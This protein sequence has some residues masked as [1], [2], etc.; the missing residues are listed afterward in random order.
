MVNIWKNIAII[1]SIVFLQV[2]SRY[3]SLSAHCFYPLCHKQTMHKYACLVQLSGKPY[4]NVRAPSNPQGSLSQTCVPHPTLREGVHKCACPVQSAGKPFTNVRGSSNPL[5]KPFTNLRG[6]S[7]P[8]GSLSRMCMSRPTPR[9]GVH[10][11]AWPVQIT[12]KLKSF[13]K[14]KTLE[15][16]R[17]DQGRWT[18]TGLP[19]LSG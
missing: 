11:C 13:P 3:S 4:T 14:F 6:S 10:K 8:Q 7:N 17:R 12:G 16:L 5:G 1:H 15:K 2:I 19:A 9:E 18:L